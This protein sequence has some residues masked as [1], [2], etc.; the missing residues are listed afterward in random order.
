MTSPLPSLLQMTTELIAAPSVSSI[1]SQWDQGNQPVIALL[2]SWFSDLGFAVEV[3]P[4]PGHAGKFNL[5][6][7]TGKGPGGLVLAGH[8]DTVPC[9]DH[10]WN[11]DPLHLS[12]RNNRLYGLGT[13]DMK[14]FF[15]L[16]IEALRS[17]ELN[18]LQQPLTIIATADEESTMCGA[19]SLLSLQQQLG[20]HA[21]IGEP[22]GLKPVR[23][24]KGIGMETLRLHGQSGHSSDPDLGAS[25]LEGM[26]TLIGEL[27]QWR[28]ELQQR[29]R[30]PL[31]A[32]EV[33]TLNLGHIHGG[34][35]PNRI[36][37][38]CELQIDI[39]PLPGMSLEA[40][41]GELSAR[42]HPL[43]K[44]SPLQ[45]ELESAFD[46][47][48]PMETPTSAEIVQITEQLTGHSAEAVA[49]GTEAPFLNQMG[50]ETIILGP[51]DIDQGHQPDEFLALD[52]IP[53]MVE[54]LRKLIHHFCIKPPKK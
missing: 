20:R 42:L 6:A 36:C 3:L 2:E 34:D 52:R 49:F 18:Q 45:L 43:F 1:S 24:H 13:A 40:L 29:Y 9:D 16:I 30:N 31:F 37:G 25:A 22:T 11:S 17:F 44:D 33:P 15:A 5:I 54:L 53:P 39:R 26:H 35:N 23:A 51:G 28:G 48:P 38:H 46:G 50:M 41:R 12:E 21:V 10:L 14:S 32:V 19:K 47:I 7:S 4:I 8:T 27:L